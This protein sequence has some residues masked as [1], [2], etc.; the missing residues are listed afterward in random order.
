MPERKLFGWLLLPDTSWLSRS[1]TW[2]ALLLGAA[3]LGILAFGFVTVGG[4][5]VAAD[6]PD[7]WLTRKFLHF[8]F[9][10]SVATSARYVEAP[11]DLSADSR[12]KLAAR[13]YAMVC[14]NCHG[15]PGIGQSA[16]AL[17]MSPRPQYLPR[18][19]DQFGAEE[20]FV[21]VQQGV[22][23]SAMPS[24]PNATRDDEVW[25]MVSFL[26]QLPKMSAD[27]YLAMTSSI[28]TPETTPAMALGDQVVLRPSDHA[29]NTPPTREYLYAAPA[30]GFADHVLRTHP[31]VLCAGCHGKEGD[32]SATGGE[33]PNLTINDADYLR[34][35]LSAFSSG[36]RKSG[37]M[38]EIASQLSTEQIDALANYY[39]GLPVH[40]MPTQSA[41]DQDSIKRGE[42]IALQG[43]EETATPACAN[44][45]ES[46]GSHL[47][48]APRIAGQSQTYIVRQ[49]TAMRRGG[50]GS[51]GFW[52]PMTA[53]AH[54][55]ADKDIKS[56]AAYYASQRPTKG[57]AQTAAVIWPTGDT[58]KGKMLFQSV[59]TKCHLND[60]RGDTAG[61]VP[62][63]TIHT[64]P[65]LLQTLHSFRARARNNTQMVETTEEMSYADIA[66]VAA[67]L[68]SLPPQKA[69]VAVNSTA[70]A[71]GAEI[72]QKGN[73]ERAIPACVG[74]HDVKGVSELPLVPRLQGQSETYLHDRLD[75]FA[76][77]P[78]DEISAINPMPAIASKLT[79]QE[80]DNLAAYFAGV[81]PITKTLEQ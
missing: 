6:R 73:Q 9:K 72:A 11:A 56:L 12:A 4:V 77:A 22:K 78:A 26:Q 37:F 33:A 42:V 24:W 44:C 76:S 58:A 53:E 17:S 30:V 34:G 71:R 63:I 16:I 69:I 32:G 19:I 15:A 70:A 80:R 29:R 31:V 2:K 41:P 13:H 10:Q 45:H 51:T 55:L 5:P 1:V 60:G 79:A 54:D 66:N 62:D 52:N 65:Y 23:F 18:V 47:S 50:R 3:F 75:F 61:L 40:I 48:H 59:C 27:T 14:S 36:A 46:A 7:G 8:T 28:E 39:A 81:A 43:I 49:L 74:C 68:N 20:L 35:A 38:Q 25:S 57:G 67:Y 64:S 21:I